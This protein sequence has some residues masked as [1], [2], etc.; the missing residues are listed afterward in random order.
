MRNTSVD[1]SGRSM[2]TAR[3]CA[4]LSHRESAPEIV[5]QSLDRGV[6]LR[7]G[8]VRSGGDL[9]ADDVDLVDAHV[10]GLERREQVIDLGKLDAVGELD[11]LRGRGREL[12]VHRLGNDLLNRIA[13]ADAVDWIHKTTHWLRASLVRA[14]DSN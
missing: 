1:R 7:L 5:H 10:A 2:R 12:L 13:L 14:G 6:E 4:V 11:L 3:P 8:F 9:G